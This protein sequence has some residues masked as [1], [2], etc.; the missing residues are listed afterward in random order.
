MKMPLKMLIKMSVK[1][2]MKMTVKMVVKMLLNSAR[3]AGKH[4]CGN[5][6]EHLLAAILF[7]RFFTDIL[8]SFSGALWARHF[9]R[10]LV[11]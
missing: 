10:L 7:V 8:W 11:V 2:L 9:V 3:W 6:I 1:M 4:A 5:A